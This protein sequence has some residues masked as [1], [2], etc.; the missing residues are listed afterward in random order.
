MILKP[1]EYT[2]KKKGYIETI[3]ITSKA[4]ER[5][6]NHYLNV[7]KKYKEDPLKRGLYMGKANTLIDLLK[8]FEEEGV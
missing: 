6:R 8:H 2:I 1:N 4:L 7:A 3:T 5:W